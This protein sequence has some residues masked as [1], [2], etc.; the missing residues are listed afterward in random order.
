MTVQDLL[1]L[2]VESPLV[3]SVQADEGTPLADPQTLLRL[4][5]AS[6]SQ[7]ARIL[8]MQGVANIQ[9]G[10]QTGLPV[11]GLIKK[12]Y[13]GSDVYITPTQ[14]EVDAL[15]QTA[16]PVIALDA[17]TR[18]R[19]N[20]E[21][22]HHLVSDIKSNNRLVLADCDSL[23]S[24]DQAI[25]AGCDLLSTTL[26]G[27]TP[28]SPQSPGPDLDLIRYAAQQAKTPVLAEG[29]YAE[30]WQARAA[31]RAGASGVVIG[32]V[33][34][35]PIKQTRKFIQAL[36][37]TNQKVGCVDIGGTWLRFATLDRQNNLADQTKIPLPQ[38][39]QERLDFIQNNAKAHNVHKIGI[40]AGGVIH[41]KTLTIT[42]AK[43]FIPDY[44]NQS[45]QIPGFQTVALNDGLA[46]A[47]GHACHPAFA[48]QRVATLTLGTG[49]G[50]G[51]ASLHKIETDAQ[52]DYPR[53]NDLPFQN[54]TLETLL[55]G[56]NLTAD[57]TLQQQKAALQ[58]LD[59]AIQILQTSF[60]DTIILGGGV[61]LSPWVQDHIKRH[62]P[63]ILPSP[64]GPDAGLHGAGWLA[65]MP[66]LANKLSDLT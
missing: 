64:Y 61:G 52:G 35:D 66:P 22:F 51:I 13:P 39:H 46:T 34:N 40:A 58:A 31:L 43:S 56:L 62:H 27:Y 8:R 11:I 25:Q 18:P 17:T 32:G 63:T 24:I 7:G 57:P 20:Q 30:P 55:G 41:P 26:S 28:D 38:T 45:F 37:P 36:K 59:F 10:L 21:L 15:L 12:I 44:I 47:Y 1:D 23:A 2:L 50:A 42:E 53:L 6:Q 49:V 9:A 4:A 33:L 16:C 3:A 54:T 48:G 29:R 60:P 5:E 14:A 19:P 65:L